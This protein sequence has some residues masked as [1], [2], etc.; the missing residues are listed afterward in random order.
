MHGTVPLLV[1]Y[2]NTNPEKDFI[3][4][5]LGGFEA[6]RAA[7]CLESNLDIANHVLDRVG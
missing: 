1:D 2:L 6:F 7:S 4:E 3:D 5:H